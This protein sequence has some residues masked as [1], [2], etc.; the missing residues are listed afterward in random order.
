MW[1]IVGTMSIRQYIKSK[2]KLQNGAITK[3]VNLTKLKIT[4]IVKP[5]LLSQTHVATGVGEFITLINFLAM[6]STEL[7]SH[8]REVVNKKNGLF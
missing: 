1:L 4:S 6:Q 8:K 2:I 7:I 3:V 5:E